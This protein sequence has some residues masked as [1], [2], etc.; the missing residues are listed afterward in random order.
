[1]SAQIDAALVK[2]FRANI[3]LGIQQKMSRLR[4]AV[5]VETTNSEFEFY[6][7][8]GSVAAQ[9]RVTR[10]SPTTYVD[11]PHDRRRCGMNDYVSADLIDRK[12][13]VRMLADPSSVY[14]QTHVAAMQRAIDDEIISSAFATVYTGKEGSTAV[15]FANDGGISIPHDQIE[16][17]PPGTGTGTSEGLTVL[18]L[19]K[20]RL[21]LD[22][23]EVT[24]D[25]TPDLFIVCPPE[26]IERLL[27]DDQKVTSAD[28]NTVKA[29][30][31]GDVDSFM[32]FKFIKTNRIP[33]YSSG[34]RQDCIAFAR[35]GLLLS[36]GADIMAQVETIPTMN[37][38]TQVYVSMS[39][40]AVRMWGPKVVKV[41][42]DPTK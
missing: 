16:A 9:K 42:I 2:A 28:Y 17:G 39:I 38:S 10:N 3:D 13:R 6:D 33:T 36:M 27:R 34:T 37:Y 18:K 20:A 30:V 24:I 25:E 19:R 40:G 32:G 12:D 26:A 1:M 4:S 15:T 23:A 8:V 22:K 5:R 21:A 41:T 31:A 35:D 29:L 11:T 7:R 14:V